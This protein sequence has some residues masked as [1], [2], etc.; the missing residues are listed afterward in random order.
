MS[1]EKSIKNMSIAIDKELKEKISI[2]SKKVGKT[3]SALIRHIIEKY[4]HLEVNEG[5]DTNIVLQIPVEFNSIE[6][7]ADLRKW[8]QIRVDSIVSVLTK[9]KNVT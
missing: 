9:E 1:D 5:D 4:I 6:K 2:A 3:T 7:E 8:L